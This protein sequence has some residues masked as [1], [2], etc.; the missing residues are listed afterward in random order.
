MKS[1]THN[2]QVAVCAVSG[3]ADLPVERVG[4]GFMRLPHLAL[5]C[6]ALRS[7]W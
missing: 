4:S 5:R 3:P 1:D 6:A 7:V 2:A